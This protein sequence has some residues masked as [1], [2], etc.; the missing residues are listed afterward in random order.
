MYTPIVR[1]LLI[2]SSIAI[3]IYFYTKDDILNTVMLLLCA[4]LFAYGYFKAGTVYIAF[5]ALKKEDYEKAEILINK[6]KDPEKLSKGQKSYY[7]FSQGAIAAK[8]NDW[9]KSYTELNKALAIGLRTEN[10]TAIVLLNL[11]NTEL[12]RKN[13]KEAN[14]FMT[15]L[16]TFE[17][18]SLVKSEADRIQNEIDNALQKLV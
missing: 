11:A 13:F 16:N 1:I 9:D 12:E 15:K 5:Q 3:S 4:G 7:Y 14:D 2:I 18:K 6:I 10:D 17:L 8:K